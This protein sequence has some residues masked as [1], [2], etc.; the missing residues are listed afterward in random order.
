MCRSNQRPHGRYTPGTQAPIHR[1]V[2]LP[3]TAAVATATADD[4]DDG[5]GGDGG[6]GDGGGGDG[7]GGCEGDAV[8]LS[9]LYS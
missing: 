8:L 6:G 4:D 1:T 2:N 7:D 5:G 3:W 9:A